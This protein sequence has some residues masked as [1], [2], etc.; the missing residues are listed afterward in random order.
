M[1]CSPDNKF[2]L[3]E[4]F[5]WGLPTF[6]TST[7]EEIAKVCSVTLWIAAVGEA[8]SP[9][10]PHLNFSALSVIVAI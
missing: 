10:S 2:I 5:E 3:P 4:T 9:A 8:T 6:Q 1:L 7:K